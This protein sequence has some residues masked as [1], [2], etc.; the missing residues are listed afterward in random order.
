[1]A[2]A[3]TRVDRFSFSVL[4]LAVLVGSVGLEPGRAQSA[5]PSPAASVSLDQVL[6]LVGQRAPAIAGAR[7]R[8]RQAAARRFTGGVPPDPEIIVGWGKGESLAGGAKANESSLEVTQ[9]LPSPR[10]ARSRLRSLD[11]AIAA[12]ETEVE[13]VVAD[14]VLEAKRLYYEAAISQ[15][16][17]GALAEAAKDAQ[18]LHEVMERR[19]QL[20]ESS[21]GDRLRTRVEALR[22]ELEA[23]AA[24]STAEGDRAALNRFLL[25]ALGDGFS[26][27]TELDP[28]RLP[29]SAGDLVALA[30]SR[31][32]RYRAAV[33]RTE[34]ARWAVTAE[35]ASRLPGLSVSFF[36]E[37]ELDRKGTGFNLGLTVPLWNRNQGP[38]RLAEAELA[39]VEAETLQ[40]K[41]LIESDVER[42]ARG[43]RVAR[44]LAVSYRRE[45]LPAAAEAL[46]IVR[47]SLDQGEANLLAWLESRR[48][49]LDILRASYRAQLEAFTRRAELERLVGGRDG[50]R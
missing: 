33:L 30:M 2:S 48:N 27:S 7:A 15:A 1:M 35:R 8:S 17:A 21:E 11:A 29:E 49:Y 31:N 4:S 16:E 28:T 42:L 38:I 50:I 13:S 9:F 6:E 44:E 39:E 46:S 24:R 5:E 19:V 10:V 34:S 20:G 47:F 12:S 14:T 37:K 40:L 3:P 43:A 45:I 18:S 26:L 25:G 41:V 36:R 22:T 23:R 32:P